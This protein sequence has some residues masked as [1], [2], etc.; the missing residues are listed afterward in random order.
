MNIILDCRG[1]TYDAA[2]KVWSAT[3]SQTAQYTNM[4]D[5]GVL[6]LNYSSSVNCVGDFGKDFIRGYY[7]RM[8]CPAL[9]NNPQGIVEVKM[10][11][12]YDTTIVTD[13]ATTHPT[14]P[15]TNLSYCKSD[16]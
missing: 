11:C 15:R 7:L 8:W 16:G 1:Q 12:C 6:S 2:N 5:F 14:A 9:I 3:T 13:L 4:G 10:S